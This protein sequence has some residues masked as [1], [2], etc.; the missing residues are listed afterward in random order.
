MLS[1]G[2]LGDATP[3]ATAGLSH[4]RHLNSMI[5]GDPP[6]ILGRLAE[7]SA[8]E[9]A[10]L[11]PEE[12]ARIARRLGLPVTVL[13]EVVASD[14]GSLHYQNRCPIGRSAPKGP[15][16]KMFS[17]LKDCADE[18]ITGT[19]ASQLQTKHVADQLRAICKH[20]VYEQFAAAID[21]IWAMLRPVL[22]EWQRESA[23]RLGTLKEVSADRERTTVMLT[24][25]GD[26]ELRGLHGS[27]SLEA[28]FVQLMHYTRNTWGAAIMQWSQQPGQRDHDEYL[29]GYLTQ[30][31]QPVPF[32]EDLIRGVNTAIKINYSINYLLLKL[33]RRIDSEATWKQLQEHN[34]SFAALWAAGSITTLAAL[35]NKLVFHP[36]KATIDY[37]TKLEV[38]PASYRPGQPGFELLDPAYFCL[39][40]E[41]PG[42][43]TLDL[44]E[45]RMQEIRRFAV[46]ADVIVKKCPALKIGVVKSMYHWINDVVTEA[47][48]SARQAPWRES[49]SDNARRV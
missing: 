27:P 5:S 38:M 17:L 2:G 12:K 47:I 20:R 10:R 36:D 33:S 1:F 4:R 16:P 13:D 26:E 31:A 24:P 25:L 23:A 29:P 35:T 9:L 44:A 30:T 18:S 34:Y 41:K 42:R 48:K 45:N 15:H 11:T 39:R 19:D 43:Q 22:D 21:D 32:K 7:M 6:S 8:D 40:G 49:G 28:L 37:L 14:Q 3:V 46:Q